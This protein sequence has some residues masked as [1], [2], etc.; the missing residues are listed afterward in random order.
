MPYKGKP[1][2]SDTTKARVIA[3]K[4]L[5]IGTQEK[6]AVSEDISRYSVNRI[7]PETVTPKVRKMA[8]IE[9]EK[10]LAKIERARD[11][12]LDKLQIKLDTE[13]V[14]P[15]KLST[16]FGTLY[17]KSRLESDKPTVIQKNL[18]DEQLAVELMRRLITNRGWQRE[19]AIPAIQ[20]RFPNVD[21]KLLTESNV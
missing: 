21:I 17:D 20:E 10:L 3:K 11:T 6:I 9:T 19:E 4:Q 18:T 13:D 14:A 16:I 12:A 5:Q 2:L 1:K 15:E 7:K 8:E